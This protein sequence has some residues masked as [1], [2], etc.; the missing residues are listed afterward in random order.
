MELK[1]SDIP[2]LFIAHQSRDH[3]EMMSGS[4]VEKCLSMLI[5]HRSNSS[6]QENF[7]PFQIIAFKIPGKEAAV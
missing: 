3:N 1:Q 4:G 5:F 2:T 6:L 7:V